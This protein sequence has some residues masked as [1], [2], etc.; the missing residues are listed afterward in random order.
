MKFTVSVRSCH[1]PD[2]PA[3]LG[4]AAEAAVG[5]DL[6]RHAGHLVGEGPQLVDHRVDR[7]A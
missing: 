7:S 5:A 2:T 6:A 1:V 3:H 4:L